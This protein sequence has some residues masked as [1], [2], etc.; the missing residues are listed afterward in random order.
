M[1]FKVKFDFIDYREWKT[2]LSEGLKDVNSWKSLHD[3]YLKENGC[4]FLVAKIKKKGKNKFVGCIGLKK[5]STQIM[6]QSKISNEKTN[7][8][9]L[10]VCFYILVNLQQ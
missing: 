3:I 6:Q 4:C 5:P 7:V 9:E 8:F 1:L 2:I 10:T